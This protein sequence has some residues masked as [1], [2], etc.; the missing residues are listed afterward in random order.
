M[1]RYSYLL[2]I[3]G[4]TKNRAQVQ[5][6]LDS[7]PEILNWMATFPNAIFIVSE[8]SASEIGSIL[9]PFLHPDHFILL[10]VDTDRAGWMSKKTWNFIYNKKASW[11]KW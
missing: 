7:R 6:F 4:I 9:R 5:V 3:N 11:E 8:K 1:T 10:D 2:V